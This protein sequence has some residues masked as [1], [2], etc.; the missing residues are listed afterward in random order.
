AL[1]LLFGPAEENIGLPNEPEALVGRTLLLE[2]LREQVGVHLR[3]EYGHPRPIELVDVLRSFRIELEGRED[4]DLG[5]GYELACLFDGSLDLALLERG[6]LRAEGD[7][8]PKRFA[9]IASVS[10]DR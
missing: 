5:T 7:D 8:D 9:R 6:V 4:D 1:R 3:F 10:D 2:V